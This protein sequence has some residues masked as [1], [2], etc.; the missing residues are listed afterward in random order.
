MKKKK[1]SKKE[2][3]TDSH[4][5]DFIIIGAGVAGL[6][7][8]MYG[9]RLGLKSLVLG[10]SNSSEL[11][12]GGVITTTN[13]VENY[14]G[15]IKLTGTELADK[16]RDHAL[17]YKDFVT[18]KEERVMNVDKKGKFF[19]KTD[20]SEYSGKTILIATCTKW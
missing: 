20:K 7:A 4:E 10:T 11:P 5:Y 9:G 2:F 3:K 18:I 19:V 8:G 6:A 14:P 12:I 1:I 16:I 15:F 17:D 13:L